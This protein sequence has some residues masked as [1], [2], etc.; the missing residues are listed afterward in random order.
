MKKEITAIYICW[1]FVSVLFLTYLVVK[2]YP[3]YKD[4]EI[5]LSTD[6][7]MIVFLPAYFS[8]LWLVVHLKSFFIRKQRI[9]VIISIII[10]LVA[11]IYS[12]LIM[13][14]SFITNV[15]I[16]FIGLTI[17]FIHYFITEVLFRKSVL[18]T[19]LA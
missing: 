1:V 19:R 18:N 12:I 17:G 14:F 16:S 2:F 5:P 3:T 8:M 9:D 4:N 10:L 13:D 6:I 11:F 15:F 7:T